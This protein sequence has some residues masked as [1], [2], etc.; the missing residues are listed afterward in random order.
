MKKYICI[1][2]F[3]MTPLLAEFSDEE[4]LLINKNKYIFNDVLFSNT[5]V[6]MISN[7]LNIQFLISDN[8]ANHIVLGSGNNYLIDYWS[9]NNYI[10]PFLN[11]IPKN[12]LDCYNIPSFFYTNQSCPNVSEPEDNFMLQTLLGNQNIKLRSKIAYINDS[13][14]FNAKMNYISSK[15]INVSEGEND[16]FNTGM[17]PNSN[18]ED[19]SLYFKTGFFDKKTEMYISNY[20]FLKEYSIPENMI[21][22]QNLEE[23]VSN[24]NVFSNY[25][26]IIRFDYNTKINESLIFSGQ[27][28][29]EFSDLHYYSDIKSNNFNSKRLG[30]NISLQNNSIH[31]PY[32]LVFNLYKYDNTNNQSISETNTYQTET[33]NIKYNQRIDFSEHNFLIATI[34]YD[35]LNPYFPKENNLLD[36]QNLSFLLTETFKFDNYTSINFFYSKKSEFPYGQYIYLNSKLLDPLQSLKSEVYG[37]KTKYSIS[38]IDFVNKLYYT[39]KL[40]YYNDMVSMI[41]DIS[42]VKYIGGELKIHYFNSKYEYNINFNIT[43][44][45]YSSNIDISLI[46]LPETIVYLG[47]SKNIIEE[48]YLKIDAKYYGKSIGKIAYDNN[49]LVN[50]H[51]LFEVNE[52]INFNFDIYNILN[53]YY[54][55][56]PGLSAPAINYSL[57]MILNL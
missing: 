57:G 37:V 15:D 25:S 17:L 21:D 50:T 43:Y 13:Y 29:Y 1:L 2:L 22:N 49:L 55:Y 9:G 45:N 12:I 38:K 7:A 28:Y 16:I 36:N 4:L 6:I 46:Y 56:Y 23:V 24:Y 39:D 47:F 5:N 20:F 34:Q 53:Q 44:K 31:H 8:S 18:K 35:L 26:D 19:F 3:V 14:F 48:L 30:A 33:I 11:T 32:S 40:L 54:E 41:P 27:V 52:V 51:I 42:N 10:V